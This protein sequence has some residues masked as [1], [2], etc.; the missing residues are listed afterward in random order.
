MSFHRLSQAFPRGRG[1][2]THQLLITET[3]FTVA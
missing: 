1:Q 3:L 2:L